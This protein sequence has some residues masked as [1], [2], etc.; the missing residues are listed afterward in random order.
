[1]RCLTMP[2]PGGRVVGHGNAFALPPAAAWPGDGYIRGCSAELHLSPDV[3]LSVTVY[4]SVVGGKGPHVHRVTRRNGWTV[5][6]HAFESRWIDA[7]PELG[8]VEFGNPA[9]P[10]SRPSGRHPPGKDS[11]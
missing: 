4:R 2:G 11:P 8:G 5:N 3:R 6:G 1:M 9:G 7:H 10:A